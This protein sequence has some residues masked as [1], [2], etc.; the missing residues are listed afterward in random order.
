MRRF[1]LIVV[2]TGLFALASVLLPA[3][4]AANAPTVTLTSPASGALITGG[5]P[6]FKG[7]AGNA[8]TYSG[9][10]T[11]SV[12][13]GTSA[14][15]IAVRQMTTQVSGGTYSVSPTM[16]LPDGTYTVVASEPDNSNPPQ[17]GTS[18]A[19]TFNIY[20]ETAQL[21]LDPVPATVTTAAPTL[22]GS[23][24]DGVGDNSQV[25]LVIYPGP[26]S[27]STPLEV[28]PSEL[29][30][31]GDFQITVDP[32]LADG[33]YT[34]VVAQYDTAGTEYS[35]EETFNVS[36]GSPALTITTP[37]A[38][39]SVSVT[40]PHFAGAA[41]N[42]YGDSANVGL[43]LLKGSSAN[44]TTVGTKTVTRSG[45]TWSE[46]WPTKLALGTYTLVATQEGIS[47]VTTTVTRTFKVSGPAAVGT[48]AVAISSSGQITAPVTCLDATG[49]CTGE[50][51]IDTSKSMRTQTGGPLGPL[52]LLF[53][54]FTVPAGQ[55]STLTAQLN[56]RIL[57]A[58]NHAGSEPLDVTVF[59][60]L[61]ST[62]EKANATTPSLTVG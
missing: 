15:G 42:A 43:T 20:D 26:N 35:N 2:L 27:D 38:G 33:E 62:L 37:V 59:Y 7:A 32:G 30:S 44:G 45:A 8:G 41:G 24:P 9:V 14:S 46:T 61:G 36:T 4:A 57:S 40:G 29:D 11:V 52:R 39:G 49:S 47:G 23:A 19:V 21:V 54:R 56:S 5:Q 53:L 3:M 31:A 1:Q 17:S 6:T 50:V 12:Y 10:V 60:K 58:L 55:T 18:S 28:V 51:L 48:S 13:K 34:A 25:W 16:A 22:S